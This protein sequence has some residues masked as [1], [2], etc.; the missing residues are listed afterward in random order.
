MLFTYKWRLLLQTASLCI[1]KNG[2]ISAAARKKHHPRGM[3]F[4]FVFLLVFRYNCFYWALI[5]A[6]TA[7]CT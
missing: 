5:S 6:G 4:L 2:G 7:I 1:L 3:V